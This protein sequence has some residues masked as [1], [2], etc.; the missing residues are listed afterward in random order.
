[1]TEDE[2]QS[3][4]KHR[5]SLGDADM[6]ASEELDIV[7]D[8]VAGVV[9]NLVNVAKAD[10]IDGAD[11]AP[12]EQSVI[13]MAD[14]EFVLKREL[15]PLMAELSGEV[16]RSKAL[17]KRLGL[18]AAGT[19]A[20]AGI[21][22]FV[23]SGR[24]A[25]EVGNL[26]SA[27][28]AISKRIVNMNSALETFANIESKIRLVDQ[29]QADILTKLSTLSQEFARVDER[30][31]NRLTILGD[32]ISS[33]AQ[34]DA[35]FVN[36]QA[37]ISTLEAQ[38]SGVQAKLNSMSQTMGDLDPIRDSIS[39]LVDIERQNLTELFAQKIAL[40]EAQLQKAAED[41]PEPKYDPEIIL[42]NPR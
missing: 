5:E 11:K 36:L 14:I 6:A 24:L 40:E 35:Q 15:R 7:S 38:L 19:I 32:Q 39:T 26:D 23:A 13:D 31:A 30:A 20:L 17:M 1:M 33:T 41:D 8:P 25:G 21:L 16:D 42:L 2:A 22:L 34:D 4:D 28:L 29:G 10:S 9:D 3:Q 18:A 27:T 37:Q 12:M